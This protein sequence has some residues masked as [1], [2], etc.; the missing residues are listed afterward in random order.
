MRGKGGETDIREAGQY[1]NTAVIF[2]WTLYNQLASNYLKQVST[3]PAERFKCTSTNAWMQSGEEQQHMSALEAQPTAKEGGI[4]SQTLPHTTHP[5]HT[6]MQLITGYWL[7]QAVGVAAHL[8]IADA[9]AAGP[10]TSDELGEA[11]GADPNSVYRLMRLLT[12][13]DVFGQDRAG[14]FVLSPLGETLLSEGAGSVRNFAITETAP[15]HWLPWGRLFDSVR[16]GKPMARETLGMELFDWYAQNPEEATFFTAA[17]G[18]LSALAAAE[19]MRVYDFS[20]AQKVVDVGG[21]HG[22]LLESVLLTNTAAQGVLYDLPHVIATAGQA[23]DPR[24]KD[25]L[26]LV[27][28]DFFASIPGGGDV[29]LLKQIIHDWNEERAALVLA[30]CHQALAPGGKLLLIEMVV[31][32]DNRPDFAQAMDLNM[33]AILGGRERTEAEYFTLLEAAGFKLQRVIATRSPFS[34]IEALRV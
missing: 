11:I 31:P 30:N 32:G 3:S 17:M 34:V 25:R 15:G 24:V 33:L 27:S 26:E 22:I 21:A 5:T 19:L 28:G 4:A 7:S 6:M 10:R 20:T 23:I 13:I 14:C 9:L 29:H 8:G 18:N 16:S 2:S 12:S 1:A